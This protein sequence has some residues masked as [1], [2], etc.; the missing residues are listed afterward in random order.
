M[1][2]AKFA[3]L[4]FFLNLVQ[5][6]CRQTGLRYN[7]PTVLWE[8]VIQNIRVADADYIAELIPVVIRIQAVAGERLLPVIQCAAASGKVKA[9]LRMGQDTLSHA[10]EGIQIRQHTDINRNLQMVCTVQQL[11]PHTLTFPVV[12]VRDV[13]K[14]ACLRFL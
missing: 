12:P 3:L 1:E 5:L 8:A 13:S 11:F 14:Y 4:L 6:F 2:L 10:I 7:I 9:I